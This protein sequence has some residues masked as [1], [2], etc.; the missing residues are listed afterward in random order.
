MEP[1]PPAPRLVESSDWETAMPQAV[2]LF[3]THRLWRWARIGAVLGLV[4]FAAAVVAGLV[5][6]AVWQG[7]GIVFNL[8]HFCGAAIAGAFLGALAALIKQTLR[9]R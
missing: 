6:L 1:A 7:R 3:G 4:V 2:P 8:G 5:P 9:A